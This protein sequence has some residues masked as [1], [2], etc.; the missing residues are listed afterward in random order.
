M[1]IIY[2]PAG[3]DKTHV[4]LISL[5]KVISEALGVYKVNVS[6]GAMVFERG[7]LRSWVGNLG[8]GTLPLQQPTI[9]RLRQGVEGVYGGIEK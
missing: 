2:A 5:L 3:L 8:K 1:E 9:K 4:Y 7:R 6:S